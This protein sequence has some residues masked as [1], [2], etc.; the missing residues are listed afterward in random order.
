MIVHETKIQDCFLV[1]PAG[2][3]DERGEFLR[4]IDFPRLGSSEW[5]DLQVQNVNLSITKTAGTF[6]GMHIQSEP[7]REHKVVLVIQGEIVDILVDLRQESPSFGEVEKIHLAAGAGAV[8][9][10]RGVAHGFQS[11]TDETKVLYFVSAPHSLAN[12]HGVNI[13][14]MLNHVSLPLKISKISEKDSAW[15]DFEEVLRSV[16]K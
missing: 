1:E 3:T 2:S 10:P 16:Q 8:L 12:E 6:R 4:L 9:V 5:Q 11:Q 13:F 15:P 7:F 14:S